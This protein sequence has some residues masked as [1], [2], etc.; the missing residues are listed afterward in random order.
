MTQ[1]EF[2]TKLYKK[3]FN[4][5]QINQLIRIYTEGIDASYL[6]K[7]VEIDD[8]RKLYQIIKA[9]DETSATYK[10][11][12]RGEVNIIKFINYNYD[13]DRLQDLFYLEEKG[14]STDSIL[15]PNFS[16]EQ[17][18]WLYKGREDGYDVSWFAFE[19]FSESKMKTAFECCKKGID[20][21]SYILNYNDDQFAVIFDAFLYCKE[22]KP[23]NIKYL[24]DPR[25][26][27]RQMQAIL[28]GLKGGVDVSKFADIKYNS[29]QM[30]I[31]SNLLKDKVDITTFIDETYSA[32][33]MLYFGNI[34]KKLNEKTKEIISN[35]Y[36][37]AQL[38]FLL[39]CTRNGVNF[40]KIKEIANP[41]YSLQRMRLILNAPKS[42]IE[43][44]KDLSISDETLFLYDK[45]FISSLEG[46]FNLDDVEDIASKSFKFRMTRN[47]PP[48]F[49]EQ[50]NTYYTDGEDIL[51]ITNVSNEYKS[52]MQ[53]EM[54]PF[55][56]H[57]NLISSFGF[58]ET[59]YILEENPT[60]ASSFFDKFYYP[61]WN[62]DKQELVIRELFSG[63]EKTY[64][65][66]AIEQM[67]PA[68]LLKT[69]F[70][71]D[72]YYTYGYE[73]LSPYEANSKFYSILENLNLN[74]EDYFITEDVY[75]EDGIVVEK[76]C[77]KIDDLK[78]RTDFFGKPLTIK[79]ARQI[80]EDEASTIEKLHNQNYFIMTFYD[81]EGNI[82]DDYDEVYTLREV[83]QFLNF[84]Y[85]NAE[86]LIGCYKLSDCIKV[87]K[88]HD[89]NAE[90]R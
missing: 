56:P 44:Y 65:N 9:N 71:N 68:K 55:N 58:C 31:I 36:N 63:D 1:E 11:A 18:K 89:F 64:K 4:D 3:E 50:K 43:K 85:R 13:A 7:D 52:R 28:N 80:L 48:S 35:D 16:K 2:F 15:S 20:L 76:L 61:E 57:A 67:Q 62:E 10:S 78:D 41:K 23:I 81:K 30:T 83:N 27:H 60:V 5:R 17:F 29:D 21:S 84:E 49:S 14:I 87:L 82:L 26:S 54:L 74:I 45:K 24:E 34:Y 39:E 69:F 79:E 37:E 22:H 51:E 90:E 33:Q 86:E 88:S 8:L 40:D 46:N 19:E 72:L 32:K 59:L 42:E 12:L 38:S 6:N 77:I 73:Y 75:G 25:L 53:E 47:Y 70:T 66:P